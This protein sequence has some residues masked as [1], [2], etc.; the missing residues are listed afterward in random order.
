MN[1]FRKKFAGHSNCICVK[2]PCVLRILNEWAEFELYV[3]INASLVRV[4]EARVDEHCA[5]EYIEVEEFCR[6][7]GLGSRL[8]RFMQQRFQ[9]FHVYGGIERK[10]RHNLT[11]QGRA[12]MKSCVRRGFL[13]HDNFLEA[14]GPP[15]P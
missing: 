2:G 5:L 11:V 13:H 8:V 14:S 12:L 9:K 3:M 1:R 6:Q 15:S 7:K 4:G 10:S